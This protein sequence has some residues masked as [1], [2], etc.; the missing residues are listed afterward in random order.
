MTSVAE[1]IYGAT[2]DTRDIQRRKSVDK[3]KQMTIID[4]KG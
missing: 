2:K 4:L 1:K 3:T